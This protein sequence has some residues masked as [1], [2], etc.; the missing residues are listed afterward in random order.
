MK[1]KG[2]IFDMDGTLVD[3][4]FFWPDLWK[5]LGKKYMDRDNFC[6]DEEIDRGSLI[7]IDGKT[8][9]ERLYENYLEQSGDPAEFKNKY[10]ANIAR[11]TNAYVAAALMAKKRVEVFAPDAMSN[12][13]IKV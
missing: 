7:I 3:S 5:V 8:I 13:S 2:A 12:V 10:K 6:P 4:L 11:L 9:R 1:I